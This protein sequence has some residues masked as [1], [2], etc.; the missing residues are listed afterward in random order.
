MELFPILPIALFYRNM[1]IFAS[2]INTDKMETFIKIVDFLFSHM[3]I[4]K[5]IAHT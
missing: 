1:G 3:N 5:Y 4:I 2:Y